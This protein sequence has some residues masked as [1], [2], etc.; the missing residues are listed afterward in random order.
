M[1]TWR[2]PEAVPEGCPSVGPGKK[3]HLRAHAIG[4]PV[5]RPPPLEH[6]FP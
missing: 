2:P 3:Q 6:A 4:G 5:G 1:N